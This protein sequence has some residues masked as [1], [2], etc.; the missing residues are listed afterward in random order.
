MT[1]HLAE[2]STSVSPGKHAVLL[3]Y[4]AGWHLASDV[5]VPN[6]IT[7]LPLPPKCPGLN[8][9]ENIWQLM[10]DNWLSNRVFRDRATSSPTAA[11]TGTA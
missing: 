2:I 10:R 5:A 1:L 9:V 7:L 6:N 11:T 3:L 8:V 4:Q